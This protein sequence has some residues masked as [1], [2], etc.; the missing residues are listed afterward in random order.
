MQRESKV[1][2]R[3]GTGPGVIDNQQLLETSPEL[4]ADHNR[5]LNERELAMEDVQ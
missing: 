3:F 1:S 2:A 4:L 5:I